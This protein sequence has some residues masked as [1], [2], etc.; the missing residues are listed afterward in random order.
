MKKRSCI[1]VS[2]FVLAL[3]LSSCSSDPHQQAQKLAQRAVE[4]QLKGE[5]TAAITNLKEALELDPQ[6]AEAYVIVGQLYGYQENRKKARESYKKAIET[7]EERI[8]VNPDDVQSRIDMA[9]VYAVTNKLGKA[10]ELLQEALKK[11]PDNQ[12]A[13]YLL[14]NMK[15]FAAAWNQIPPPHPSEQK[16]QRE[17]LAPLK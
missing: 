5:Y 15:E 16:I 13:Q 14:N 2:A 8:R 10:Q 6:F 4:K 17:L 7:F 1:S 9:G 12:T 11:E 3:V